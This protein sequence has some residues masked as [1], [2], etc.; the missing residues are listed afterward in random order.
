ML[1]VVVAQPGRPERPTGAGKRGRR[2]TTVRYDCAVTPDDTLLDNVTWHALTTVQQAFAQGEGAAR[3]YDPD[4]SVFAA[5]DGFDARAWRDLAAL[6]GPAGTAVL[7]RDAVPPPPPGWT[8]VVE[9]AAHQMVL[10]RSTVA[11][12]PCGSRR[13]RA[14]DVAE[15]T[16]LVEIARPGPFRPR[17]IEL[18]EYHGVFERGSLVAL[19]G[20]RQRVPGF[21]EVSAVCTHPSARGRGLATALTAQIAA[22]ILARGEVPFLHHAADNDPAHR[23]YEALGFRF[24]REVALAIVRAPG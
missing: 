14:D 7:F 13:L 12:E 21:T 11:V 18:G 3:R 9:G 17:T 20:E 15:M 10:D 22:G 4:V 5:V 6:V 8:V 23:V 24:R 1:R 19:A 16:A 2:A